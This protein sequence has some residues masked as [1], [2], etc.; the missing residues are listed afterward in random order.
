MFS[1]FFGGGSGRRRG[2][3]MSKIG[4]EKGGGF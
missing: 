2:I 4:E 3:S 1:L